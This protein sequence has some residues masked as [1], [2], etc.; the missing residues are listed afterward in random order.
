MGKELS[1][2]AMK[3]LTRTLAR[4]IPKYENEPKKVEKPA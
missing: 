2:Q 1:E 4:I 3:N